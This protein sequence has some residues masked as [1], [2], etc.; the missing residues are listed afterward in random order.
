MNEI[1]IKVLEINKKQVLKRLKK[2]RAKKIFSG[3]LQATYFDFPNHSLRKHSKVLRLRKNGNQS[4]LTFKTKLPLKKS[5][6]S[7]ELEFEIPDFSL[8]QT[9]LEGLGFKPVF[10]YQKK[11][12]SYRFGKVRI[13]LD[14]YLGKFSKIPLYLEIEAHSEK[15]LFAAFQKLGFSKKQGKPWHTHKLFQ[16]YGL[17]VS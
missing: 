6:S 3:L 2:L 17:P 16:Y 9:M 1:E 8:A 11:R 10:S 5:I 13:E 12:E 15:D 7:N 14:K 4:F